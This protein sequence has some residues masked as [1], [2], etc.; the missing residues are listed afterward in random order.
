MGDGSLSSWLIG[1]PLPQQLQALAATVS[2]A[3]I[4]VSGGISSVEVESPV[5][6]MALPPPPA[7]PT[8]VSRSL[9]NR[10]YRAY[11]PLP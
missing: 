9:P 10:F 3:Y 2:D 8:L 6:S 4:F 1:T 5:Y 11:W 7:A